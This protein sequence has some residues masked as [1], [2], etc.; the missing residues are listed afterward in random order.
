MTAPRSDRW[1]AKCAT[2]VTALH[3]EMTGHAVVDVVQLH[4]L[5][6]FDPWLWSIDALPVEV[7]KR[8]ENRPWPPYPW[9]RSRRWVAAHVALR[10][11][12]GARHRIAQLSGEVAPSRETAEMTARRGCI[13]S[14]VRIDGFVYPADATKDIGIGSLPLGEKLRP[15]W[16]REQFG[17]IIGDVFR[18]PRPVPVSGRQKIWRVPVP[19]SLAVAQQLPPTI[20]A[21]LAQPVR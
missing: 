9:V 10:W 21:A 6:L 15:W 12:E 8:L 2:V 13:T 11:D 18:L 14:M 4:A 7:A 3:D 1:C 19:A 5:S 16:F 17:W 20:I